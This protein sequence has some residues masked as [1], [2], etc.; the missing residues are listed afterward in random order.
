MWQPGPCGM[1]TKSEASRQCRKRKQQD[2]GGAETESEALRHGGKLK[3][4]DE[5]RT[6]WEFEEPSKARK[7]TAQEEGDLWLQ[8]QQPVKELPQK[9]QEES[10]KQLKPLQWAKGP[11]EQG[12]TE[13]KSA[14]GG[15]GHKRPYCVMEEYAKDHQRE[16]YRKLQRRLQHNDDTNSDPPRADTAL[17]DTLNIKGEGEEQSH[18][19]SPTQCDPKQSVV[20]ATRECLSP[21]KRVKV[22]TEESSDSQKKEGATLEERRGQH[23]ESDL[24]GAQSQFLYSGSSRL[25]P[26]KMP[27]FTTKKEP[28]AGQG[29]GRGTDEVLDVTKDMEK[30]IK[31]A[32]GPGPQEEILSSGFKLQIT[33]GDIQT[34]ETGQWLNDEVIN[35]Y[36]NLLVQRN[37]REGY[38]ALHAFSTFFYPKL[39][40][41]GYSAVKRW[42]RRMNLFE[43]EIILVPIHQEVHWSLIVIDLRKCSIMYYDSMGHTGQSICETIFQYLQ[44][45]SKTRRNIELDPLE[46]KQYSMTSAEIPQQLN[47]SDCGVFTCKYADYVSRDQPVTFSQQHMPLFRKRMVWEILHSHLI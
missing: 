37:D 32:L 8:S 47:G 38:P 34:L 19:S 33:R 4:Q 5:G 12:A 28:V 35:F 43:K 2:E 21:D 11:Q 27:I 29:K 30:E 42:T 15:K 14:D 7:R 6:D 44:N 18:G 20:V 24:Q 17:L 26:N 40:H 16:K 13:R 45:E 31:K 9:P 3:R 23:L 41:G 46:W 1:E 10:P 25:L 39:K 22:S 36:T